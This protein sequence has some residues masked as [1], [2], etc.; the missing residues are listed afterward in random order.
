MGLSRTARS[1]YKMERVCKQCGN[2]ITDTNKTGICRSCWQEQCRRVRADSK[3]PGETQAHKDLKLV[4]H[5]FLSGL[6][7]VVLGEE[8]TMRGE[9]GKVRFDILGKA[10]IGELIAV[11]CGGSQ[12]RKLKRMRALVNSIYILPYNAK[13]PYLWSDDIGVCSKCGHIVSKLGL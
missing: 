13:I 9:D 12:L 4:A 2:P 3:Y 1:W 5:R 10:K 6:G 8:Y 11:E 7:C